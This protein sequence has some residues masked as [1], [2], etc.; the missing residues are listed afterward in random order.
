MPARYLFTPMRLISH[1]RSTPVA[2]LTLARTSSPRFSMSA[3]VAAPRL[4]RK[5]QCIC[6]TCAS[7]TTR[8]RQPARSINCHA[9]SPGGFLKVEPPVFSR[10]G[11]DCLPRLGDPLHLGEDFFRLARPPLKQGA[12]EDH[13]LRRARYGDRSCGASATV[14]STISPLRLTP[15]AETRTSL[16]SPPWAP[17]FIRKRAAD[18][19][20][21]AAQKGQAVDAGLG[22]DFGD[23]HVGR[24]RAG[25]Q[26]E[27]PLPPRSRR[28]PCRRD[29]SPRL[30]RRRRARSDWSRGRWS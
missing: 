14:N 22:R 10:I 29:E 24:R 8:P 21:N 4:I 20:G 26:P 17:A 3:A 30:R 18:G 11:C 23:A 25:A 19:A 28:K 2:A 16:V 15:R 6:D 12:G 5:L 27:I 1:C 9:F 13:I 7:P